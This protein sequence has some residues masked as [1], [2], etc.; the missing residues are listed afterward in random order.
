MH[1]AIWMQILLCDA[2]LFNLEYTKRP[3][4]DAQW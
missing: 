1:L 2:C 4:S 3:K